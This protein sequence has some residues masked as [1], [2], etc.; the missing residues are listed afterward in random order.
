MIL[1]LGVM[2]LGRSVTVSSNGQAT[3]GWMKIEN[4]LLAA[5]ETSVGVFWGND[6]SKRR[7]AGGAA[8]IVIPQAVDPI[9]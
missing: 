5:N 3:F 4:M 7:S 2:I 6:L 9:M 1:E 8:F